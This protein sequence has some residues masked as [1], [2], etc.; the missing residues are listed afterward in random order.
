MIHTSPS[1]MFD[2]M[3]VPQPVPA[4]AQA[5]SAVLHRDLAG[6][7][8]Q[9]RAL[10]AVCCWQGMQLTTIASC[11][12][13]VLTSSEH[14]TARKGSSRNNCFLFGSEDGCSLTEES[15]LNAGSDTRT[16]LSHRPFPETYSSTRSGTRPSCVAAAGRG[17]ADPYTSY[18][19]APP[20]ANIAAEDSPFAAGAV[21]GQRRGE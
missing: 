16:P 5:P 12:Y 4:R 17:G 9:T 6:G 18:G 21:S 10:Q 13:A 15:S 20:G 11:W 1:T 3:S 8:N 2:P 7:M 14:R 19:E